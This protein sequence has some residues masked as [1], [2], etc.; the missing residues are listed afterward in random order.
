MRAGA[1]GQVGGE[2]GGSGAGWAIRAGA[3]LVLSALA[4]GL[5]AAAPAPAA[6]TATTPAADSA[7]TWYAAPT[8]KRL[9]RSHTSY[10]FGNPL[11]R[12]VSPLS[13][14]EFPLNSWWGGVRLGARGPRLGLELEFLAA[15]HGQDDIGT[16]RDS[17]WDDENHT[18][19]K[20]IY[21]ESHTKLKESFTLDAKAAFSL[22]E[23]LGLPAW[24]D[25]R[26]LLGVR[27]QRFTLV[28]HDGWQQQLEADPASPEGLAWGDYQPLPGDGIWFRQQYVH[29]YAGLMLTADLGRLGLGGPD[30]PG[31]GWQVSLQG[32]LAQV[33]G[34]NLDRH[35]LRAG[36][37]ETRE[38]TQGYAWHTALSLRAPLWSWGSLTLTGDYLFIRTTG[39]HNLTDDAHGID[40][41][42]DYGVMVW[43]QQMSLSLALEIPF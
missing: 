27:W 42:F 21:S 18:R 33:W 15:L 5:A 11:D 14:L 16:M 7:E 10:E 9:F 30:R 23:D 19:V 22:R 34:D 32:D 24:L 29:A 37:R 12:R 20:T 25:L 2:G 3:A 36:N 39:E 4:L 6:A 17:D 38:R 43:S 13:R 31:S 8:L 35:L 28:T 41:T 1:A 40:F 26:P